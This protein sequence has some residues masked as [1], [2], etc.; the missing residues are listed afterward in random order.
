[1]ELFL[2]K[3]RSKTSRNKVKSLTVG[4]GGSK[5]VLPVDYLEKSVDEVEVYNNERSACK[6]IRLVC[7]VNAICTNVLFNYF[8]E[9]VKGEG[10][11]N[12]RMYNLSGITNNDFVYANKSKLFREGGSVSFGPYKY[13]IE[14][15]RD[16]Q[17]S[18]EKCGYDYH[19]GFDIFNNHTLRS[20]TFKTVCP[21]NENYT[22]N[23]FNTIA[24]LARNADGTQVKTYADKFG[25][26]ADKP[27]I[28]AHLYNIEEISSFKDTVNEKLVDE[29]GWMGFHNV[30]KFPVYDGKESYDFSRT[31]N[32][33]KACDFIDMYPSR[34]LFS[35]V[36]KYN[37]Y[38]R[39][40]EKNWNYCI[41]YPSSST[42]KVS[43]IREGTN[44]LKAFVFD[45]V[46]K[47]ENG[48]NGIDIISYSKHGLNVGDYV[49]IYKGDEVAIESARVSRV[50][51]DYTFTINSVST[52]SDMWLSFETPFDEVKVS[53]DTDDIE[54]TYKYVDFNDI[55]SSSRRVVG[56]VDDSGNT[57][58][59]F[60]S[61]DIHKCSVDEDAR[62]ISFKKLDNGI[63]C[64]YYVRIFSR[65]PNWRFAGGIPSSKDM[66][67]NGNELIRKYQTIE[68][69]F[70]NHIAQLSFARNIYNDEI[71]KIV[72]TDSINFDGLTDNLGRPLSE[73]YLT[74]VKNNSGYRE[75]YGKHGLFNQNAENVE[76]SH[77]FGKVTSAFRLSD[78]SY[79]DKTHP[80]S[81][82][83][84]NVK[85]MGT[86]GHGV[87]SGMLVTN[88]INERKDGLYIENDE[89][90]YNEIYSGGTRV[91]DGDV[92]FYG[93]LCCYSKLSF[94]ESVIQKVDFRF[95][96]A[97]RE[98]NSEDKLREYFSTLY[99]DEI[100]SDDNDDSFK[101]KTE[102]ASKDHMYRREGYCY[103]PHYRIPVRDFSKNLDSAYPFFKSVAIVEQVSADGLYIMS[104][105]KKEQMP[106]G[107][108]FEA[109]DKVTKTRYIG[110]VENYITFNTAYVR[111]KMVKDKQTAEIVNGI[112]QYT[113]GDYNV[114]LIDPS[115]LGDYRFYHVDE[116]I[117]PTYATFMFDG[118]CRFVWKEI[119][120]NGSAG[121]DS[122][123]VYPF[124]NNAL[125]VEKNINLFVRRQDPR[126]IGDLRGNSYPYDN[127]GKVVSE[128]QIDEYFS[129]EEITC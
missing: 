104:F 18:M 85:D 97:Q 33:R 115:R 129:E 2:D 19:C 113:V 34:D 49:N 76:Y 81:L 3:S 51:N 106:K 11:D 17:L 101:I 46:S 54:Y 96:T 87:E 13:S 6:N 43:F 102:S 108:H 57:I 123:E 92:N 41:T 77:C 56:K 95:N 73:I 88:I 127:D 100:S 116:G 90:E 12:V 50:E 53:G 110:S 68:N 30:E 69:E 94:D 111:L 78:E 105:K 112:P 42:T 89:I 86:E 10:T 27:N 117:I 39:R 84:N 75:W 47:S 38:R 107:A 58:E 70:E 23:E 118:T 48:T 32:N 8:T 114:T 63:E 29:F 65:M 15:V 60:F 64:E 9:I 40:V 98:L 52:L 119:S 109:F 120:Y 71:G 79:V 82:N 99:W 103:E 1:M 128:E 121:V 22:L 62:D 24:D 20:K 74:I 45:D 37:P 14:G 7:T 67:E 28:K 31:I 125:Y 61:Y 59:R 25:K 16:T 126:K 21:Y 66:H 35:F 124:A 80:S 83:I 36:P 44:S 4:L 26:T 91:Y 72:F 5:R 93:D 55:K 122:E